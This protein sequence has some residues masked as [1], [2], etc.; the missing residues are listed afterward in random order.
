MPKYQNPPTNYE[1]H[2]LKIEVHKGHE[3]Q[4]FD[5]ILTGCDVG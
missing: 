2:G 3:I 1:I 4:S 5:W